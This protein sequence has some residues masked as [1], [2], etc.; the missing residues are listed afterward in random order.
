MDL[1]PETGELILRIHTEMPF[2]ARPGETPFYVIAGKSGW[3][4]GASNAW[5]LETVLPAPYH[6]IY[7]RPVAI[8]RD[9]LMPFMR[10]ELPVLTQCMPVE[11]DLSLDL[12]TVEPATP[13]FRLLIRGSPASL[14]AI[15]S[16]RYGD[17]ELVA[18]KADPRAHFSIP[19]PDDLMR[20]TIRNEPAEREALQRLAETGFRGECGDLLTSIVD[21]R[22][23]LNFMGRHLPRLR[24]TGWQIEVEGKAG[25]YLEGLDFVTPV[26]H[27]HNEGGRCGGSSSGLGPGGWFDV[28][29]SFEDAKGATLSQADIQLALR[30][31]ESFIKRGDRTLLIDADA[32]ESMNNV[33]ADCA[34]ADGDEAGHFR[35]SGVYGPFVKASLDG[36]DGVDVED[37]PEWRMRVESCN[38]VQQPPPAEIPPAL[39]GILR[40]YQRQGVDWLRFLEANGFGGILADEMGLGKTIQALV[41]LSLDR[42]DAEAQGDPALVVCPTSIVE[43]WAEEAG[44]FVPGLKV[45]VV[46]GPN[47]QALWTEA[48][49]SDLVVTSYALLR[50]DLDACLQIEFSA[51]IL[52]EAQHIKNRSTQN[53]V[54]AKKVRARHRLVL[55]GT[56][57]ENS[58]SDLWSLMDFLMPGYLGSHDKFRDHYERPIV[59]GG[60]DGELAQIK[61]RRKLHPFLMR[62]LKTEVA[63]DLPPKIEKV[64]TC[65]LTP[66]QTL[67]Y[68]ELLAASRRKIGDLVAKQGFQKCRMEILATL[69]RLRQACCHLELL[70]LPNLQAAYPS[71]KM[72]LFFELLDEAMDGGHRVLVF[73]QFVSMLTILRRELDTRSIAYCYLDGATKDRLQIVHR[74][75]TARDIPV[76]LISLKA[77]G[78]GLNLTGAD[79]VI[80]FDPWWNPAVEDQATDRAYRIGQKR[81]VYSVKLITRGTVEEKV[82]ALQ[83]RKQAVISATIESDGNG[84]EAL[85]NLSW[86]DIREL[87]SL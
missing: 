49:E 45:T 87:L 51:M 4:C 6:G 31:G 74:F 75:N 71:A 2:L 55:T 41:W 26:V 5:P 19:D 46:N 17:L 30:R 67:V 37:T 82:L 44:R 61:L 8:G 76:F 86:E 12:F 18:N 66:D 43:N 40:G 24:R 79:M 48:A 9:H 84:E 7:E 28:A 50:R 36:L 59:R 21:N 39:S 23:V 3:A 15:L 33:F 13:K 83:E 70:K 22:E 25:P 57:V 72:D 27:V 58:V 42:C 62:R 68:G 60:P 69:M 65:S 77:G 63:R 85:P 16:A 64:S 10:R 52:D 14:S 20:Y 35:L 78:T 1:N 81:T 47:R 29:F 38:R 80:H 53:A 11:T 73:S 32:V 56:P 34:A 54:A